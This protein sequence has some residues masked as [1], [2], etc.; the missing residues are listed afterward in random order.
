MAGADGLMQRTVTG[1]RIDRHGRGRTAVN[2]KLLDEQ[3][4]AH[5]GP[6]LADKIQPVAGLFEIG[7]NDATHVGHQRYG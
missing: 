3:R 4:S 6:G 5:L 7:C 2:S 1:Q